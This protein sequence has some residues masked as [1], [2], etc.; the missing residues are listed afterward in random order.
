MIQPLAQSLFRTEKYQ[1]QKVLLI[2]NES[3]LHLSLRN[4][5]ECVW[6][7]EREIMRVICWIVC[8]FSLLMMFSLFL[9]SVMLRVWSL[10]LKSICFS[11]NVQRDDP[12]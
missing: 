10:Q 8:G 4:L 11:A 3:L 6:E 12:Q 2:H 9:L 5:T 7:R 1:I